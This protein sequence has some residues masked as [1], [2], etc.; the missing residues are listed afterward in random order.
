MAKLQTKETR[1]SSVHLDYKV[2]HWDL[3]VGYEIHLKYV[4]IF[5]GHDSLKAFSSPIF[6]K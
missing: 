4:V 3:M 2:V 1:M 5:V 6:P